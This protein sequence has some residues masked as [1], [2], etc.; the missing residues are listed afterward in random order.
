MHHF[1]KD[2]LV[3]L[4]K[5][6]KVRCFPGNI[7]FAV[8]MTLNLA[9][10]FG[11]ADMD[12][13]ESL[14]RERRQWKIDQALD[15][16]NK[17]L[18]A[19]G[20]SRDFEKQ[21][22]TLNEIAVLQ[23]TRTFD[24]EA[25]M[26]ALIKALSI[27]ESHDLE[28]Q[29][30]FTYVTIAKVFTEVGYYD[31]GEGYLNA[32][33]SLPVA[34]DPSVAALVLT[35]LGEL[36]RRSGSPAEARASFEKVLNFGDGLEKRG[37]RA[38]ALFNLGL[39]QT[40]EGKFESA[41]NYHKQALAI[42]RVL[43]D[44]QN[45]ARMLND[46]GELYH[47]MKRYDK[48]ESN[49]SVALGI[50]QRISDRRGIAESYNN[51]GRLYFDQHE[52]PK[53]IENLLLGLN[54]GRVSQDRQQLSRSYEYLSE[55]YEALQDYAQALKY[56]DDYIAMIDLIQGEINEQKSVESQNRYE[57]KKNETKIDALEIDR[58][59]KQD[60]LEKATLR[61]KFYVAIISLSAVIISIAVFFYVGK[62]RDSKKLNEQNLKLQELNATKDKFFSIISHDLKG[63]LNS[64]S[65][66]SN[67]LINHT[68]SLS[69]EEI[70]ML[71][72]DFDKSL[73]NLSSLLENLLD[74]SRSQTGNIDFTAEPF[75]IVQM[76]GDNQSLLTSQA[77]VKEIVIHNE[78]TGRL[79]VQAH[80]NSI[81]TVIRNLISNA[82]K[83]TPVK[84]KIWITADENTDD[85]QVSIRDNGVGMSHDVVAKLFRI[86]SKHSTKG[87][88]NEKGTGLGL[89]LCKEFVEKNGGRL[90]VE[91]VEG[92]GS[93][94]HF[95]LPLSGAK[96]I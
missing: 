82:I 54:E 53:A 81:S 46:V 19:A 18:E 87:T 3:V 38:K 79:I 68:D 16:R 49:H 45:E 51:L 17:Q 39:L 5:V 58:K 89:I 44:K 4:N 33:M 41:L 83:F 36:K 14:F 27:E 95:T 94:F 85:V 11:Q 50:R 8:L 30:L 90:W 74:W 42:Y 52:I 20:Q 66:F 72:R 69:K 61:Q 80:K 15:Q 2:M 86:D 9:P 73:K 24:Y 64:L 59:A 62:R 76:L 93:A 77:A 7:L 78:A 32:A 12:W 63:P 43:G 23:L 65:S 21:A 37:Y 70:T 22:T 60:A 92:S 56:K 84:G 1:L 6:P 35:D 96:A 88:A 75:D 29:K 28:V 31:K 91:S 34:D 10:V 71:A 40:T 55:C 13:Y 25:A 57:L 67:L 26:D 47:T 48:S